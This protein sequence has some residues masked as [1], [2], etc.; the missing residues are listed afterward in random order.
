MEVEG[1]NIAVFDGNCALIGQLATN[2]L[3][4]ARFLLDPSSYRLNLDWRGQQMGRGFQVV[5]KKNNKDP[6]VIQIQVFVEH[7]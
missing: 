5:E 2:D 7:Q 4:Q 1:A 3:G 6:L